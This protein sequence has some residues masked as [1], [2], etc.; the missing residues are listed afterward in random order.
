MAGERILVIDDSQRIRSALREA[1][2]EPEGYRVLTAHD[3][4]QGL[5]RA[6]RERPDL[7]LL[8]VNMPR[9]TGLQ[10]IE[11][12]QEARYEWPVILMTSHGS[13]ETAVQAFRLGVRDYIRKPFSIEEVLSR[14]HRALVESRLRREREELLKRLEASNRQL[15]RR[16]DD[17]TTLYAIGQAVT[18]LL[19]LD[20]VLS[21]V[22]EASVYL[23]RADEGV[24][25][26]TDE[27]T[28]ELYMT[29]AQS[30]GEKVAHGLRL[31][32]VD[33]LANQVI[34][35]GKPMLLGSKILRSRLRGQTGYLVHSLLSVPLRF[36]G[37]TIG[38]LC[39]VNRARTHD[40]TPDDVNRLTA[41][42]NYAAIA[43]ENARLLDVT[44]ETAA[45]EA[46][47]E[48][49]NNTVVTVS[50]YVN[51][52]LM[53]LMMK[54]D[55]LVQAKREGKLLESGDLVAETARFTEMKVEEIKAV[56]TI[57]RDLTSP[58]VVTY[59][60]NIKMLDIE[61]LV[62]ERLAYIKRKYRE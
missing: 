55:R 5:E 62:Q 52:P 57:L 39:V 14:V 59:I 49:L 1:I 7:I 34:H 9:M 38:V 27:S 18:S 25:Y 32:V 48:M 22:V 21:R 13:E 11:K 3:G 19:D 31:R 40:F 45:S 28:G 30:L 15:K 60:D 29:A 35:T 10:F 4:Q 24:L 33:R 2:L 54:A 47:A 51:N 16:V 17:L 61:A 46:R 53:S 41:I 36:K 43:I 44:R 42:A 12:L 6:L 50:H 37:R 20:S 26:L 23:C 56:L 58:Q 8:D